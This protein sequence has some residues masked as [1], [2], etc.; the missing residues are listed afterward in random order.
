[1]VTQKPYTQS[2]GGETME[3]ITG[4]WEWIQANDWGAW[5]GSLGLVGWGIAGVAIIIAISL[6]VNTDFSKG[7]GSVVLILSFILVGM[8][9]ALLFQMPHP[10][11][12]NLFLPALLGLII[13]SILGSPFSF[14]GKGER[15]PHCGGRII[16]KVETDKKSG[17]RRQRIYCNK[18]G[19]EWHDSLKAQRGSTD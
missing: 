12:A 11:V 9:V 19:Y 5:V 17:H 16:H 14:G 4:F 10:T 8:V 7:C 6:W 13:G 3:Q 18:C 15:C 2:N 1:M